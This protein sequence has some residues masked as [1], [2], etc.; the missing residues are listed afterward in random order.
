MT[1]QLRYQS[2]LCQEEEIRLVLLKVYSDRF[3][4]IKGA[5]A[6]TLIAQ[7]EMGDFQAVKQVRLV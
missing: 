2:L 1:S 7:L 3:C 6:N 4:W 5:Q